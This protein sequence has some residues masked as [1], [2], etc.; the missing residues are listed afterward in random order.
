MSNPPADIRAVIFDAVGT[1]LHPDPAA[2]V[3]YSDAGRRR[4]FREDDAII[5]R[6]F[7]EAFRAEE[8]RDEA[9]GWVTSEAREH[10]R[11]QAIVERVFE[12]ALPPAAIADCFDELWAY[13]ARPSSWRVDP[14]AQAMLNRLTTSGVRCGIASNFDR[15]LHAILDGLPELSQLG[16]RII[17]S[18]VGYRKPA[19]AFFAAVAQG[20]GCRPS[21]VL[22]VG[23]D[24]ANDYL[25][26]QA[27]GMNAVL[28]VAPGEQRPGVRC[29][30]RLADIGEA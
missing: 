7:H 12:N 15:R 16:V 2:V 24:L 22:F 19:G 4:G 30:Q 13:F 28:L 9:L 1:L 10:G 20:A 17:S 14:D 11:W 27:A 21:Q 5:R 23:D 18:E 29:V 26:A 25:G 8:Q 3:V 6:R